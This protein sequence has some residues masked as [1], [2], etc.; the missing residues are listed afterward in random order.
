MR[1]V[2]PR[3][4][5]SWNFDLGLISRFRKVDLRICYALNFMN[6]FHWL[7]D[8]TLRRCVLIVFKAF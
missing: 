4:E 6:P 7:N 3:E 5:Q 2:A 1:K 8:M